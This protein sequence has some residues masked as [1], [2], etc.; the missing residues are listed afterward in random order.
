[1]SDGVLSALAA[2][3]ARS[4]IGRRNRPLHFILKSFD[5]EHP[6]L[7]SLGLSRETLSR[8]GVGYFTGKGMMHNNVVIPFHNG[9][10]LLVAYVGYDIE[11]GALRYPPP[12]KFDQRL[13]LFN[14][15]RAENAGFFQDGVVLVTDLLNVLRLYELGIHRVVALTTDRI[16]E[17]Q[18]ATLTRLVGTNGHVDFVPWSKEYRENLERL[19]EHFHVRL[20]RYYLGSEDE[21]LLQVAGACGW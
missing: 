18:L 11:T 8:F 9:D 7:D 21:F 5:G 14:A 6:A 15:L 12:E 4:L 2:E 1:M 20:H 10:G 3:D 17:P 19:A 13:E 16:Y